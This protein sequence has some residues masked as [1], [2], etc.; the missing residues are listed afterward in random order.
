MTQ[1]D[2]QANLQRSMEAATQAD[3]ATTMAAVT[4]AIVSCI[5][6]INI[7]IIMIIVINIIRIMM[8]NVHHN[9][10]DV[11][12]TI[13]INNM[14]VI[15]SIMTTMMTNSHRRSDLVRYPKTWPKHG[16]TARTSRT[17]TVL[18]LQYDPRCSL[19]C[20]YCCHHCY[21]HWTART[22]SLATLSRFLVISLPDRCRC[23]LVG[24]GTCWSVYGYL[25]GVG[26]H[27][28]FQ[29]L[30]LE[31]AP[32]PVLTHPVGRCKQP[33]QWMRIVAKNSKITAACMQSV[34]W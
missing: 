1:I 18:G 9:H 29:W 2:N 23:L 16:W 24:F 7:M 14:I 10:H 30:Q 3:T 33:G 27:A 19:C 25:T 31:A 13:I 17:N 8:N 12:L 6:I 32:G 28:P 26:A 20:C 34:L 15:I 22:S 21:Q 4:T 11:D 5:M